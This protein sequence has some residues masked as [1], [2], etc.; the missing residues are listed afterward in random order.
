MTVSL[1]PL[2]FLLPLAGTLLLAFS[3][4]RLGERGAVWI[5]TGSV[6]LAALVTALVGADFALGNA[7][8]QT[9]TL[10]TWIA[11]GEFAPS[12]G[13]RLDAL[14]LTM[15]SVITGVGFLIH[16]FAGWY[17]RGEE[18]ITRFYAYMNLFVFSMILL[19]LGDNLLLLFLGWEGVGLC[20][21]LL[22]GYYYQNAANGAAAMKAFIVTRIGDVFL[23]VGLF[24]LFT[25]FGT[26][27]IAEL[28]TRATQAWSAGEPLAQLA[29]LLILGGALGKSAQL[30]LH[31]WLADAMA[32]PTPVSALIHAATMVTAGVYLIARMHGIF[33][34]APAVLYL[35][36]MI[37]A[38]TLLMAGFAALAQTDIKRVLAYSTMSQIGYMFL[39]LGVGAYSAGVFHLVT[40]A[41]FKALLFLA[42]GAVIVCCRHEQDIRRLGGLRRRLPL[43]Y[44][45]FVVGGAALAALPLVTAGFYSKDEILWQ[46]LAAEQQGLLIAGL[47]GS[48]LT[49]LY[50]LRLI[51]GIF[52]GEPKSKAAENAQP[53]RGPQHS[54]PLLVL[55]VLSTLLGAWLRPDLSAVFPAAPGADAHAGHTAVQLIASATA[56][57]GIL[58]GAWLFLTQ[59]PKLARLAAEGAGAFFWRWWHRAFGFDGLYDRVLVRPFLGLVQSLRRDW[60]DAFCGLAGQLALVLHAGLSRSQNGQLRH[61]AIATVVGA[62]LMVVILARA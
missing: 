22:I 12:I 35:V 60:L 36:G 43:A 44:L 53:G 16:W 7:G 38:V 1:L 23:A 58:L 13:L 31:T 46:A 19:V 54:V 37:G 62:T 61:Y 52:H 33:E 50:T 2:T 42:A 25:Q 10:Y 34:L 56:I 4:G 3:A 51:V 14:S 39:A 45:S 18:G 21:Y 24:L 8:P 48:L 55:A 15:L 57:I 6:G 32:G 11:V 20:S 40:H 26:L 9:L 47:L 41:F 5:G 59:G 49:G 29:A 28:V 30:P 17:M 27:D